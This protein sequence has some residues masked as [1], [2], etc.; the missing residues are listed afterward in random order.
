MSSAAEE[1]LRAKLHSWLKARPVIDTMIEHI[2]A[3]IQLKDD[4]SALTN[5]QN[6]LTTSSFRFNG[7]M[8]LETLLATQAPNTFL[9]QG[10]L[11]E[12]QPFSLLISE[13]IVYHLI[14]YLVYI[15]KKVFI[16]IK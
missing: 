2:Y 14:Y 3:E 7:G 5:I 9:I 12:T 10:L 1:F 15:I 13:Q 6:A 11:Y 4:L 16:R 8:V